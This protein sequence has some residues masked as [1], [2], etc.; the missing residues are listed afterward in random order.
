[1]RLVLD[2]THPNWGGQQVCANCNAHIMTCSFQELNEQFHKDASVK[3][4]QQHKRQIVL[5]GSV[6]KIFFRYND[7]QK[8]LVIKMSY[9]S[10]FLCCGK[11]PPPIHFSELLDNSRSISCTGDYWSV[12]PCPR[13]SHDHGSNQ[14]VF[15]VKV[16]IITST[17]H[18][19]HPVSS[20]EPVALMCNM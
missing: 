18:P 15:L 13:Y 1:M 6:T 5:V 7:E 11:Q 9:E 3:L 10:C 12:P 14:G 20:P 19:L 2:Y 16:G 8:I 17:L 4:N